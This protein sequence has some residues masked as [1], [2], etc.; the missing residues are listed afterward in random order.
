MP[1]RPPSPPRDPWARAPVGVLAE[2]RLPRWFVLLAVVLVP[3]A[4]VVFVLAFFTF[5]PDP[6]ATPAAARRPPPAGGFSHEIGRFEGGT[7]APVAYSA[8]CPALEGVRIAGTE[9]DREMLRRALAAVC[10]TLP[11]DARPAVEAFAADGG[12]IRFAAFEA[13]GVDST[14]ELDADPPRLL[15]NARFVQAG[16]P[17]WIS[18]LVV[19][20]AVMYAG[21]PTSAET[22]LAARR[23]EAETCRRVLGGQEPSRGCQDAA[24]VVGLDDPYAA[25]R[26]AGYR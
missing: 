22:A 21:D 20:D 7:A 17:R 5:A 1:R 26:A 23:A 14:V 12:V 19:H 24:E 8:P 9:R 16:R 13:T 11:E 6:D 25:L 4:V 18:P 10:T 15:V 2:P 3:V